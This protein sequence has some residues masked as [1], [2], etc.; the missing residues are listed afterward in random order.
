MRHDEQ[1]TDAHCAEAKPKASTE[2][3][4]VLHNG[5][6]DETCWPQPFTGLRW[7]EMREFPKVEADRMASTAM[8]PKSGGCVDRGTEREKEQAIR[9]GCARPAPLTR[10]RTSSRG[11]RRPA[12]FS[13]SVPLAAALTE[14]LRGNPQNP[15]IAKTLCF[16]VPQRGFEPLTHAL[17]MR[18]STN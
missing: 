10:E 6:C 1:A 9:N 17:R 4:A 2:S 16:M 8:G 13:G 7:G 12:P 5:R 18:C 11:S 15:A 3:T 14:H